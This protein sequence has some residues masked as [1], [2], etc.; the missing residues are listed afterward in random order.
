MAK[1][2]N[3]QEAIDI[4]YNSENDVGSDDSEYMGIDNDE[5]SSDSEVSCT[6]TNE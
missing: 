4:V 6:D 2:F 1:G 5:Q 3:L